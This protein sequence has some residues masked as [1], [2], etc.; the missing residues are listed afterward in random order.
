MRHSCRLLHILATCAMLIASA[1]ASAQIPN[2]GRTSTM[3]SATASPHPP[4]PQ[5][6]IV[7]IPNGVVWAVGVV[8]SGI[9]MALIGFACWSDN[10]EK[11]KQHA[12]R[13]RSQWDKRLKDAFAL[14]IAT[15]NFSEA[16]CRD[17]ASAA[18]DDILEKR[19]A[20]EGDEAERV[21]KSKERELEYARIA[22]HGATTSDYDADVIVQMLRD[23][24]EW[25]YRVLREA[26]FQ[27]EWRSAS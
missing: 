14:A 6:L 23:M 3:P 25:P 1:T 17:A 9:F 16:A 26:Q 24:D 5:T 8:L 19:E 10:Q 20:I 12:A 13:I 15:Q 27:Y 11:R 2:L 4:A 22:E 18:V 7:E 21:L